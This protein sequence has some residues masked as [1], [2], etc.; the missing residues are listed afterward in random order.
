MAHST[1]N[2]GNVIAGTT[3][4]ERVDALERMEGRRERRVLRRLMQHK[5]AA[6]G[7]GII[8]V[9]ILIALLAS[10]IAPYD[11]IG[12]SRNVLQPPSR[13]HL[14]GTDNLGRDIFSRVVYGTRVSLQMGFIAIA[15]A[16]TVGTAMGLVAGTYGGFVDNVLMRFVDALMA[17]PGILLALTV[18]AVLGTGLHTAMI[19][20]GIAWIPGFARIVRSLVLQV[21]E[22]P[23]IEAA[24]SLGSSD[25]RLIWRHVL[26]NAL[27]PVLVLSSLGIGSAVLIGA[28]LSFLGVGAQPPTAEWGI[29]LSEG[30]QFMRS[31]WWI[32][33]FPGLAITVTVLAAN[34][35]GDGLRDALDPRIKL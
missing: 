15:I 2:A 18:A 30:R 13:E 5:S 26:P 27:T 35:L 28:A 9:L 17:V 25:S 8:V 12:L 10:F 34:L 29:M 19:A 32:M 7:F 1:V 6:I 24:R 4:D 23:Y 14:M 33:A 20:V 31:A 21:K 16:A 3:R 22:M 11:P